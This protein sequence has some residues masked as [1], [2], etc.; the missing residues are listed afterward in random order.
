MSDP[1]R[2]LSIV[3]VDAE[4]GFSGGEVQVFQLIEGLRRRGHRNLLVCPPASRAEAQARVR[5]LAVRSVP[6]RNDLD[7]PALWRLRR[8]FREAAP[9]LLHLHTGRATWLGALAAQGLGVPALTTRRMDR[10]VKRN[11]RNRW[12]YGRVLRRT[13]AISPAVADALLEGGVDPGRIRTIPSA[14]DPA[15]LRPSRSREAV[16]AAEGV[17]PEEP[18]LLALAALVRRKGLDV[19]LGALARL[20]TAGP[21]PRLWIA[22]AG[23]ERGALEAQARR[24]GLAERVRFLGRREDA[25]DLLGACDVFVLPSRREG[26]GVAALEAMAAGRAV[27]ASRV[28]GLASAVLEG[29]TG[30]L[31]PP[32]DPA[33]LAEAL[34]TLIGDTTLRAR[35]AAAGPARVATDFGVEGMVEAYEKLYREILS[36]VRRP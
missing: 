35:L 29:R 23:P 18:L 14:V 5:G 19:L 34:A 36:E 9:D 31:V 8:A 25:A 32:E 13:V 12:L 10:A 26:L 6:M 17:G 1:R 21:A 22:G 4:R 16:R 28:G 30:L 3:H 11:A 24:E 33:A 7:L 20:G 15:A 2:P 27:V